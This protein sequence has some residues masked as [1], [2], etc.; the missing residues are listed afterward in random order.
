MN[1]TFD[2]M[3][4][5]MGF[6]RVT[7]A[8]SL[9]S[10][11]RLIEVFDVI[12]ESGDLIWK[13]RADVGAPWNAKNAGKIAGHVRK[14]GYRTVAI[15]GVSYYVHRIIWKMVYGTDPQ[16]LIDHVDQNKTNNRISNLRLASSSENARNVSSAHIDSKSGIRGVYFNK[17]NS[18]WVASIA[19]NGNRMFLGHFDT[20]EAAGYA[21]EDARKE[22]HGKFSPIYVAPT[23]V[24]ENFKGRAS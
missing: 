19:T 7:K 24:C 6:H 23:F 4:K 18:K 10:Q 3:M 13:S 17:R 1:P 15:N 14:D 20:A 8:I 12:P 21:Y 2:S 5:A 11:E 22:I 16:E 9:P